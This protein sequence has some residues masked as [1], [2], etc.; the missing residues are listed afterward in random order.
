MN[1]PTLK[2]D[3]LYSKS[4][5]VSLEGFYFIGDSQR[6]LSGDWLVRADQKNIVIEN[7]DEII[8]VDNNVLFAPLD[9][10][11]SFF[12]MKEEGGEHAAKNYY[13]GAI[14]VSL[15]EGKVKVENEVDIDFFISSVLDRRYADNNQLEFLKVQVV[16]LRSYLLKFNKE[17]NAVG[18]LEPKADNDVLLHNKNYIEPTPEQL[19]FVYTGCS[20]NSNKLVQSAVEQTKGMAV[21]HNSK[22]VVLPISLCCGGVTGVEYYLGEDKIGDYLKNRRDTAEDKS[23]DLQNDDDFY[24][25]LYSTDNCFCNEKRSDVLSKLVSVDIGNRDELYR[26]NKVV[27]KKD[28]GAAIARIDEGRWESIDSI[29]IKERSVDGN[30]KQLEIFGEDKSTVLQKKELMLFSALLDLPT[31]AFVVKSLE[32]NES[33]GDGFTFNGIGK[34]HRAGLCLLG[35]M[36][37]SEKGYRMEEIIAHYFKDVYISKQY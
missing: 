24:N 21:F 16:L 12:I 23:L 17:I 35:T 31:T 30:I 6:C 13:K 19:H 22:V 25:W 36:V 10:E 5:M 1:N 11:E 7:D 18:L 4:V 32:N 15:K 20:L 2:L 33:V 3:I 27:S 8:V 26:W 9:W 29:S 28:I 34:G 14:H 37:M